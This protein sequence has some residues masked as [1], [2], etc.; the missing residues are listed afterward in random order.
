MTPTNVETRWIKFGNVKH[1]IVLNNDVIVM[2]SGIY[3]MFINLRTREERIE[4]FDS[5]ERGKG[6]SCL[7]AHPV[8]P[9]FS[10]TERRSSP[11]ISIFTYPGIRKVSN[12]VLERGFNGYLSCAFAGC[13]Y[14]VSLTSFPD[15]RIIVWSWRT[16]EML[17]SIDT[18]ISDDS[19]RI[20]SSPC[21]PYQVSQLGEISGNLIVYEISVCSR[22]VMI[23]PSNGNY[24]SKVNRIVSTSWSSDGNLFECDANGNVVL[25]SNDGKRRHLI[26]QG[27]ENHALDSKNDPLIET[28]RS[29]IVLVNRQSEIIFYRKPT[30]SERRIKSGAP[31]KFVWS[32]QARSHPVFVTRSCE[33][34]LFYC[35]EGEII[36]LS[37]NEDE[38]SPKI[39]T[40]VCQG[41]EYKILT[42]LNPRG[43]HIVA[44]DRFDRLHV[45]HSLAGQ[46]LSTVYL[47][48]FGSVNCAAS[49]PNSPL[50]AIGTTTGKFL[51]VNL[52]EISQPT[53]CETIHL[54][55]EALGL[56]RYSWSTSLLGVLDVNRANLFVI[57]DENHEYSVLGLLNFEIKIVD[58]LLYEIDDESP[59]IVVLATT[60]GARNISKNIVIYS[61]DT[62]QFEKDD[63]EE[64]TLTEALASNHQLRSIKIDLNDNFVLTCSYDGLIILRNRINPQEVLSIFMAHHRL[65]GGAKVAIMSV[66]DNS[67][68]S[69]GR[70]GDLVA[71]KIRHL[72]CVEKVA[73]H[74][75][76]L[77]TA[78]WKDKLEDNLTWIEGK[79]M[80]NVQKEREE[81]VEERNSILADFSKLRERLKSL[82]DANERESPDARLSIADFDLDRDLRV[83]KIQEN[84]EA[85]KKLVE[86]LEGEIFQRNE[87]SKYL[88]KLCWDP[89]ETQAC[90]LLSIDK[91]TKVDNFAIPRLTLDEKNRQKWKN[92]MVHF[93]GFNSDESARKNPTSEQISIVGTT[94]DRFLPETCNQSINQIR[95]CPS[96]FEGMMASISIRHRERQ[97]K[98][99]FNK[100]FEEMQS[101]KNH[102]L[103]VAACRLQEI[104]HCATELKNMFGINPSRDPRLSQ[105]LWH[106]SEKPETIM[107][108][109][110]EEISKGEA[111]TYL[112]RDNR[113]E[114]MK[115]QQE[116]N[117]KLNDAFREEALET[118]MDGLLEVRWEDEIKKDPPKPSCLS[119][120][121]PWNYTEEEIAEMKMYH[122][123]CEELRENREKYKKILQTKIVD[124][125]SALRQDF[126]D[127][128]RKLEAFRLHRMKIESAILQE[129]LTRLRESQRHSLR[130]RGIETLHFA[131]EELSTATKELKNMTAT[132]MT[133]ENVVTETR[134]RYEN[135]LKRDKTL[136]AKFRGD[137]PD[138]K[139]PMVEHLLRHY[140]KRPKN[141]QLTCTSIT[142]LTEVGKCIVN[143]EESEILPRDCLDFLRGMDS[144]DTMP[145]NLPVQIDT[146]HWN[147]L[148]KLRRAKVEL[149]TK[150]KICA[151][152]L[153]E[154]EQTFGAHQKGCATMDSRV[155]Q[156]K[157][158]LQEQEK[159]NQ[160]ILED[161]EIQ[162][163]LKM[164]QV[165]CKL[166]GDPRELRNAVL[167][168][169]SILENANTAIIQAGRKKLAAMKQTVEFRRSI[170][171][172][173]WRHKCMQITLRDMREELKVLQG[174]K[175]TK[176]IQDYL[177]ARDINTEKTM[178]TSDRVLE[179][180]K[181]RFNRILEER[182]KQF[183]DSVR[184]IALWKE[185]NKRSLDALEK[186]KLASFKIS[187]A[188][189]NEH[190][191]RETK[192]RR[193]KLKMIMKRTRLNKKVQENYN[194]LLAL[195]AQLELLRLKTYPTLRLKG[196]PREKGM[197]KKSA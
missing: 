14:L 167:V 32:I 178:K 91:K 137:F 23:S 77:K 27:D 107:T 146:S 71:T 127:F 160:E 82:L 84:S 19:Q 96:F 135:L 48:T 62:L 144:L 150:L 185:K 55:R 17:T 188:V 180:T 181:K 197:M 22:I 170:I 83:Q 10:S 90:S 192:H 30:S 9:M 56:L 182:R 142:Y 166:S 6:A 143:C 67:V 189:H 97:L 132:L 41:S 58:L 34:V 152:D 164:G 128:D 1:F 89:M 155:S 42:P 8:V 183:E 126:E 18:T 179:S 190:R 50:I 177:K 13:E 7:A 52:S 138:L 40:I 101:V 163:V 104:E 57:S 59:K 37:S 25:N 186:T 130:R 103:T 66:C 79:I 4:K 154:A 109:T 92:F 3:V 118:M 63:F 187:M 169:F 125:E 95:K 35:H 24:T 157:E 80:L 195:Q 176:E 51:V 156:L 133:L 110:D 38:I 120:K 73:E 129:T 43:E 136:D 145:N 64:L 49:H 196:L 86:K 5:P 100:L 174:V 44:I 60:N 108:I 139:Q 111:A 159:K 194:E 191:E 29:G 33:N 134:N 85:G 98:I 74:N 36:E 123:K 11:K 149:E 175:V 28:F 65:E 46:L 114:M 141:V 121:D 173:E 45:L 124:V 165:E 88:R 112:E 20:T 105:P 161:M 148:C 168:P 115:K 116:D 158:A 75:C 70:N 153:A 93:G 162:L 16:G 21:S 76:P 72:K 106:Y 99:H 31:W 39:E 171:W 87:V 15:F 193:T 172:Q 184:K 113:L 140:R 12:C 94:T 151:V 68:V 122:T 47:G 61:L 117:L 102:E 53:I 54:G 81:C 69:L 119:S 147:V 78:Q 131:H 2:A 26:V